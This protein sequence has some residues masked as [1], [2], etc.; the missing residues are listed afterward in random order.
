M[1]APLP[2]H[3][4]HNRVLGR[5]RGVSI[6]CH[7]LSRRAP[8]GVP[9][10]VHLEGPDVKDD[11]FDTSE[12]KLSDGVFGVSPFLDAPKGVQNETPNGVP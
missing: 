3:T 9:E 6:R 12:L 1:R 8:N 5:C 10:W 2:Y 11:T 7:Y 4:G